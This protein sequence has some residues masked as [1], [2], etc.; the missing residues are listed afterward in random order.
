VAYKKNV[1]DVRESPAFEV[2]EELQKKGA[3]V[4]F[5]DPYVASIELPHG[6]LKGV[7]PDFGAYDLVAIITDHDVLDRERLARE[8]SL[9]V[10]TR[11]ALSKVKGVK[12]DRV[13]GL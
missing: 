2:I 6:E 13:F 1:S 3:S 5:T 9:I 4:A 8:A 11:D 10:D 12:K 7:A